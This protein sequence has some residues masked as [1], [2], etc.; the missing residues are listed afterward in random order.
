MSAFRGGFCRP[1]ASAVLFAI[2]DGKPHTDP[3]TA[4]SDMPVHLIM[5]GGHPVIL[6]PA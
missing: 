1:Q 6:V 3:M 5:E 2:T 4:W